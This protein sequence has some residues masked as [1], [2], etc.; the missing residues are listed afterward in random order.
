MKMKTLLLSGLAVLLSA[1]G[2]GDDFFGGEKPQ[3]E[4][5]VSR[6]II[7][8]NPQGVNLEGLSNRQFAFVDVYASQL[9]RP[10]ETGDEEVYAQ[11]TGL[12]SL[13]NAVI[14]C[15]DLEN[16]DC[17][18]TITDENGNEVDINVP[19][20]G[21]PIDLNGG[22]GRLAVAAGDGQQGR[23]V[24]SVYAEG[25]DGVVSDTKFVNFDVEYPSTGSAYNLSIASPSQINP[26]RPTDIAVII[27]DEAGNPVNNPEDSNLIVTASGLAGTTLGF[28]G[29]IGQSVNAF[30]ESGVASLSAIANQTGLLT[31]TANADA[32]DNNVDNG[33]QQLV[34]AS[35]TIVVT[36]DIIPPS[37]PIKITA[38]DGPQGAV[39]VSYNFNIPTSGATPVRFI[40][41]GGN[42]PPG[43]TVNED[44]TISGTPSIAGD[45]SF[46]V[47][48]TGTDGSTDQREIT[49]EIVRGGLVIAPLAFRDVTRPASGDPCVPYTQVF[50]ISGANGYTPTTP[51]AWS[52][53][54]NGIQTSLGANAAV[55]LVNANGETLTGLEVT[56]TANTTQVTVNGSVCDNTPADGH[57]IIFTITDGNGVSYES[58]LPFI[59]RGDTGGGITTP[60]FEITTAANLPNGTVSTAYSETLAV[61]G[62]TA[63]SFA[64]LSGSLPPGLSLD[65]A[66][67]VISGNP[68]T[69]GT[70][71][72]EVQATSTAS[73]TASRTFT[74]VINP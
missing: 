51:Y 54:A 46:T 18:E 66:T 43:L 64:L 6:S 61:S 56:V 35:R 13:F 59:I 20:G 48:V 52:M 30:T 11:I 23:I 62:G 39:G 49:I 3:I 28:R 24:L 65:T 2:G 32:A 16:A 17:Y 29:Q 47:E 25:A 37:A 53:D 42:V 41:T 36:N 22:R 72:F 5:T 73:E 34:T 8:P 63:S 74:I 44:G 1:C 67:G 26:N 12:G 15:F 55:P 33:I 50:T 40:I 14:Y 10:L 57:A 69:A 71:T 9:D 60:S 58:V 27:T 7:E 19:L 45:Y 68:T 21:V 31:I 70:Y 38:S 4:V